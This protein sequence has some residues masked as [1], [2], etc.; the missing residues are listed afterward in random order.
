MPRHAIH[1]LLQHDG[2]FTGILDQRVSCR[3]MPYMACRDTLL[4]TVFLG[5]LTP[6]Q[7]VRVP[8]HLGW[9]RM[10]FLGVFMGFLRSV[11]V[12]CW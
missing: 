12:E 1:G 4:G 9:P 5:F 11:S 8:E 6:S 7:G 10:T 3:G 2:S